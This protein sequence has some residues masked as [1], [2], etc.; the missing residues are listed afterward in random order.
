MSVPGKRVGQEN[1]DI[2]S[3]AHRR[4]L[5]KQQVVRCKEA[6]V[7]RVALLAHHDLGAEPY[8]DHLEVRT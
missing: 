3:F 8:H 4:M 1:L 6:L 5:P 7:R 2:W